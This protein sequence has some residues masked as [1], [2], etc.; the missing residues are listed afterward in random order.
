M[1]CM[2]MCVSELP[3]RNAVLRLNRCVVRDE[4]AVELCGG[5][6]SPIENKEKP[7]VIYVIVPSVKHFSSA[8]PPAMCEQDSPG[9]PQQQHTI[10]P[11]PYRSDAT[12]H[13]QMFTTINYTALDYTIIKS[14]R[15]PD[16]LEWED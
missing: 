9:K 16:V 7:A 3:L 6:F 8:M 12:F 15:T 14:I 13:V 2:C 1:M 4:N 10:V 5:G 11:F